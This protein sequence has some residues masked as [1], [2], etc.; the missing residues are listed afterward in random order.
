MRDLKSTERL[1]LRRQF[2]I[3]PGLDNTRALLSALNNPER[4]FACIHVAGTNGKGSVCAMVASVLQRAGLKVGLYT[5]PHLVRFNERFR[6]D[7]KDVDDVQL[8]VLLDIV[9][10]AA[11]TVA[12]KTGAD[13]TFFECSTAIAFEH[14][15]REGVHVAVIETGLGGRLDATNVVQ[16]IATAITRVSLEHTVYLGDTLE[17]VAGEK[18]G[19]IKDGVPVVCGDNEDDVV[20]VVRRVAADRG[21]PLI[22]A[23][24]AVSVA[25]GAVSA[26]GQAVTV[27]T[28]DASYGKIKLPLNGIYQVENLATAVVLA[29]TAAGQLG[30]RLPEKIV[31]EGIAATRWSGRL[32]TLSEAPQVF[33][34]GAHN[35]GA[36]SALAASLRQL[37]QERPLGLVLGMCDDKSA[38]EFLKPFRGLVRRLW[39]VPIPNERNMPVE[40]LEAAAKDCGFEAVRSD[41]VMQGLE[42]AR[43]WATEEEG[44]VCVLGSL[45]LVGEVLARSKR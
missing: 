21:A 41:D 10:T 8:Q 45:F 5:S 32:M 43:S 13:A 40:Q 15:R 14:F 27:E 29:E 36:A 6:V 2:G 4:A 35:P 34:D 25:V 20:T 1:F 39:C 38:S 17:A 31:K 24:D 42:C 37:V 16:P 33:L 18:C 44:A 26:D 23:R 3:K 7:G 19:I 22:L 28:A 12:Q 30:L 9:E 11:E